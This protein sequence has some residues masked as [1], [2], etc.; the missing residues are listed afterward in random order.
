MLEKIANDFLGQDLSV[1]LLESKEDKRKL[2]S[3]ASRSFAISISELAWKGFSSSIG[4]RDYLQN[5]ACSLVSQIAYRKWRSNAIVPKKN[6]YV[7][8]NVYIT[9]QVINF[10]MSYVVM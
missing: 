6:L 8:S 10:E 9:T 4:L 2:D 3:E 7:K 5:T 1:V